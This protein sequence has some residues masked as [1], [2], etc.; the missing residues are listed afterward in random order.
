MAIVYGGALASGSSGSSNS[1]YS[2]S[3]V[4]PTAGAVTFV[5][6]HCHNNT[7]TPSISG[8]NLTWTVYTRGTDKAAIVGVGVGN[9]P[10]TGQITISGLS[11]AGGMMYSLFY[12]TGVD[13]TSPV[14]QNVSNTGTSSSLSVTLAA[15]STSRN[16]A[17]LAFNYS[18]NTANPVFSPGTGFTEIHD[19]DLGATRGIQTEYQLAEDTTVTASMTASGDWKCWGFEINEDIT[20]TVKNRR[21][22]FEINRTG[23][24]STK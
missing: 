17:T 2:T 3:S 13:T 18:T 8:C 21:N 12:L 24:R 11:S 14:Q 15:F 6:F 16:N 7:G 23:S 22:L 9:S 4:T 1:S 10:S 20:V 5:F 19:V